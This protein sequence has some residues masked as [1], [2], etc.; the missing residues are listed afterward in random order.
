[1][2]KC[3][4]CNGINGLKDFKI[5]GNPV[6]D[7]LTCVRN[8][9]FTLR[10]KNGTVGERELVVEANPEC[11]EDKGKHFDVNPGDIRHN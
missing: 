5:D 11:Q 8:H 9:I 6:P 3:P 4:L 2:I 10:F 1:M 7:K